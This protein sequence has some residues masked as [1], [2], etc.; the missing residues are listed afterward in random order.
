[1]IVP[2]SGSRSGRRR[3]PGSFAARGEQDGGVGG[4]DVEYRVRDHDV[5]RCGRRLASASADWVPGKGMAQSASD[6]PVTTASADGFPAPRSNR[7]RSP[8]EM[9][10][11]AADRCTRRTSGGSE[12]PDAPSGCLVRW[13]AGRDE[14]GRV[15]DGGRG[16]RPQQPVVGSLQPRWVAVGTAAPPGSGSGAVGP[17]PPSANADVRVD[18]AGC[19]VGRRRDSRHGDQGPV[20]VCPGEA[21]LDQHQPVSRCDA[22][23]PAGEQDGSR[24]PVDGT[25]GAWCPEW[26]AT[27][28]FDGPVKVTAA[29][30]S[31]VCDGTPGVAVLDRLMPAGMTSGSAG[32][33]GRP[34][35]GQRPRGRDPRGRPV[36]EQRHQVRDAAGLRGRAQVALVRVALVVEGEHVGQVG[37]PLKHLQAEV[38]W[39]RPPVVDGLLAGQGAQQGAAEAGEVVDPVGDLR[40]AGGIADDLRVLGR[41]AGAGGGLGAHVAA[42]TRTWSEPASGRLGSLSTRRISS[43]PT[44][45]RRGQRRPAQPGPALPVLDLVDAVDTGA[46]LDGG[47]QRAGLQ[48]LAEAPL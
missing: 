10:R 48:R 20:V 38:A 23:H 13:A 12:S 47:Q 9:A 7:T 8:G 19:R 18:H 39:C 26:S 5:W 44:A 4:R 14:R 34:D 32:L 11:T 28:T 22:G 45:E 43:G 6:V 42:S 30:T 27:G 24:R 40:Q 35:G 37:P 41:R 36:A 15:D 17:H 33:P 29:S 31:K 1:M 16:G 3:S 25:D 2:T 46:R 21:A